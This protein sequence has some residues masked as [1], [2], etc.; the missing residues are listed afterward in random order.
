MDTILCLTDYH[1]GNQHPF[2]FGL[3]LAQ[4]LEA[5]LCVAHIKEAATFGLTE[6]KDLALVK[7]NTEAHEEIIKLK[8]FTQALVPTE[9][10]DLQ[11]LHLVAGGSRYEAVQDFIGKYD[12]DL[13]VMGMRN[14]SLTERIFGTLS[15]KLIYS[16]DCPL[17]LTP[18][19]CQF[20]PI[21]NIVYATDFDAANLASIETLI[22]WCQGLN[23]HLHLVHV[24]EEPEDNTWARQQ[25]DKIMRAVEEENED[26]EV[27]FSILEGDIMDHLITFIQEVKADAVALT[28]YKKGF[29][30]RIFQSGL[31]SEI[32]D[33]V[34]I[35][36]LI[37]KS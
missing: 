8:K 7:T 20:S 29:W 36:V 9:A 12:I 35:P 25:M 32:I 27:S 5:A 11:L 26:H 16:T 22:H 37:F 23:A 31:A 24:N 14:R 17:L 33:E 21:K 34:T 18:P 28:A 6:E 15:M 3:H 30:D 10:E 4:E 2:L 19:G 13:V 1:P